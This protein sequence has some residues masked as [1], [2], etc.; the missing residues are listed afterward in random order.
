MD[1]EC[2]LKG[3]RTEGNPGDVD[4]RFLAGLGTVALPV[5]ELPDVSRG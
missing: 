2:Y 4:Q 3:W 5:L 1:E